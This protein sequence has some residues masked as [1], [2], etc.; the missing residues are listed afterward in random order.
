[1]QIILS[2]QFV[3]NKTFAETFSKEFSPGVYYMPKPTIMAHQWEYLSSYNE[4][5]GYNY[6][7]PTLGYYDGSSVEVME[8]QINV[9]NKAG[10]KWFI[11]DIFLSSDTGDIFFD[12]SFKAYLSSPNKNLIKFATLYAYNPKTVPINPN[13]VLQQFEKYVNWNKEIVENNENYL[14]VNGRPV[15]I[16]M[17]PKILFNAFVYLKPNKGVINRRVLAQEF[18]EYLKH[19]FLKSYGNNPSSW[20][21][22]ASG[23]MPGSDQEATFFGLMGIEGII[24]YYTF[25][26]SDRK[27]NKISYEYYSDKVLK[28]NQLLYKYANTN[29]FKIVPSIPC[30]FSNI[31]KDIADGEK[32]EVVNG[33]DDKYKE[34][35]LSVLMQSKKEKS[36]LA[37]DGKKLILLGSWAE[38][39]EG[40]AIEPGSLGQFRN[41]YG[42]VNVV[43]KVFLGK[44][45]DSKTVHQIPNVTVSPAKL[46]KNID[47]KNK[48]EIP[49]FS[50]IQKATR[51]TAGLQTSF[52]RRLRIEIP[53]KYPIIRNTL[54][55]KVSGSIDKVGSNV[56]QFEFMIKC[57]I[58]GYPKGEYMYGRTS[59]PAKTGE[60]LFEIPI[61]KRTPDISKIKE[62]RSIDLITDI[63]RPN[64]INLQNIELSTITISNI[65][66]RRQ[67]NRHV[68]YQTHN[69]F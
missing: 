66:L 51:T 47:F 64:K 9:A 3:Y 15:C 61:N 43:S 50:W 24:P 20:P 58:H 19:V 8:W 35:L 16:V 10:I 52:D 21:I 34:L 68:G 28:N 26:K 38:W 23:V 13:R 1:M 57:T 12:E 42:R 44:D 46:V 41:E 25:L 65:T 22:L 11:F 49:Y 55:V 59:V 31:A 48:S 37:M 56:K 62:I 67:F 63:K 27:T 39:L 60:F 30:G 6:I 2:F 69:E 33:T 53:V 32:V 18:R 36:V 29:R 7:K 54:S 14:K 40:N 45:F 17:I 5:R 4:Y